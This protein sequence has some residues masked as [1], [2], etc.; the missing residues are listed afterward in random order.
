MLSDE[1]INKK[2]ERI[3]KVVDAFL[4]YENISINQLSKI[5]GIP[6]STIQ[7]D[8]N[9]VEYITAI[10]TDRSKEVLTI[11]SEKLKENK[12]FG[13]SR[14]GIISTTNN[15]PIRDENGKFTGNKKR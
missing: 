3:K 6:S 2:T 13:L 5:I 10:Y 1:Q 12:K 9:E 11:I 4:S 8:L 7:R 15:M 14:G